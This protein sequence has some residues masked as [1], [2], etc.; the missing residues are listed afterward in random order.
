[1]T[2]TFPEPSWPAVSRDGARR[3]PAIAAAHGLT[4]RSAAAN[5]AVDLARGHLDKGLVPKGCQGIRGTSGIAKTAALLVLLKQISHWRGISG[6]SETEPQFCLGSQRE[7][8]DAVDQVGMSDA[9]EPR[10]H[11]GSCRAQRRVQRH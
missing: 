6:P 8:E 1:M 9:I 11:Q 2:L 3:H 7:R 4:V 10:S 5:V